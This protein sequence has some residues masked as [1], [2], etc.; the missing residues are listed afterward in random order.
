VSWDQVHQ[1][2]EAAT[3]GNDETADRLRDAQSNMGT[4]SD[5]AITDL[6]AR[7]TAMR[8]L[9]VTRWADIELGPSP[10]SPAD[11]R[12]DEETQRSDR[13]NE[14]KERAKRLPF[15]ASGGPR[16]VGNPR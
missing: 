12:N 4:D 11:P 16:P 9:G 14:V 15:A 7:V 3:S 5:S 1:T 10:A 2:S 6:E 13:L 8:R